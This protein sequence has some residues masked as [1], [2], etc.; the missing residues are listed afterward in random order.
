MASRFPVEPFAPDR[1]PDPAGPVEGVDPVFPAAYRAAVTGADAYRATRTALR[2]VGRVLRLGNRFV[3]LDRY[4]EIAFLALGSASISQALAVSAALGESVTQGLVVG[5]DPLPAEVPF[6]HRRLPTRAPSRVGD[7]VASEALELARGLGERDLLVLLLSSG[8]LGYL[9]EPPAGFSA[10][11]WAELSTGFA[12]AGATSRESA[13]LARILGRGGV[14]GRIA[15][16]TRAETAALVVD[17]GDGADVVGGGPTRAVTPEERTELKAALDRTEFSHRLSS[18][19]LASL[20]VS[21]GRPLESTGGFSRPVALVG[22]AD[23]LRDAGDAAQAK[24]WKPML[25][26]LHLRGD[27]DSAAARFV[28]RTEE[29]LQVS[30][31]SEAG[32]GGRAPRGL[33]TFAATTLE[34]P[35]GGDE[36][37]AMTRFL[38]V[39]GQRIPWRSAQIG[40]FRTSGAPPDGPPPGAVVHVGAAGARP[41][42]SGPRPLRMRAGVTDVGIIAVCVVPAA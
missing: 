37:P 33:V 4:R 18:P 15:E 42:N 24:R 25:A 9:L 30:P 41:P 19:M 27:A 7:V 36:R 34:V 21:G 12:S 11:D 10:S 3:P 20:A 16:A 28:T 35:E 5:P 8:A 6:Q 26:E 39:A 13:L 22:P 40:A 29:L 2:R 38:T 32:A 1:L 23:A 17:R 31:V 14:G